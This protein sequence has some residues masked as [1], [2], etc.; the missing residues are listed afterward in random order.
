MHYKHNVMQNIC[1]PDSF[2]G[3]YYIKV[4]QAESDGSDLT[5][6]IREITSLNEATLNVDICKKLKLDLLR[7]FLKRSFIRLHWTVSC[8]KATQNALIVA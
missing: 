3:D 6:E 7:E 5:T 4:T 8:T 2:I 1:S